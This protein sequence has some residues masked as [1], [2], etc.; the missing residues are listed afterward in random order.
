MRQ[1]LPVWWC[2]TEEIKERLRLSL[3]NDWQEPEC[4]WTEWHSG[5]KAKVQVILDS[6]DYD[7]EMR[8][9]PKSPVRVK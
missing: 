6:V 3:S 7:K 4:K 5:K 1:A 8:K 2:L 9:P